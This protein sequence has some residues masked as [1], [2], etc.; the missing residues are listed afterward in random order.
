MAHAAQCIRKIHGHDT[1][2]YDVPGSYQSLS[3]LKLLLCLVAEPRFELILS[4]SFPQQKPTLYFRMSNKIDELITHF[5][6]RKV[7]TELE[8]K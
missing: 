8:R 6:L 1:C 5:F 7:R 3:N 2:P 4:Y